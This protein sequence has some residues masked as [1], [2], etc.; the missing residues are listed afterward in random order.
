M[1]LMFLVIIISP[2]QL[3]ADEIPWLDEVTTPPATFPAPAKPLRPL[4]HAPESPPV[5]TP[6]DWSVRRVHLRETWLNFLGPIPAKPDSLDVN[7]L[8]HEQLETISRELIEYNVEAGRR[9][10]A[11]VLQPLHPSSTRLPGVVVFHSTTHDAARSEAGLGSP[12][13]DYNTGVQLA[14]RGFVVI[15]PFNFLWEET[16]YHA[17]VIEAKRRNPDSLG[18][19]TMLNDGLRA[20]DVLLSLPKIDP[21]RIGTIGHSLGAKEA[22]Y[23]MAFDDRIQAG[24]ASEGGLA[25]DSTN[26]DADWYLGPGIK[27]ADFSRDHHEL[28]ALIAPRPFLVMGGETG[29]GCSDGDR[30]WPFIAE[31]HHVSKLYSPTVR[32]GLLNHH[33][34]HA[35]SQASQLKGFEWLDCYVARKETADQKE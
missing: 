6:E 23:L 3:L 17:S 7:V 15:C 2:A 22:L 31:A 8:K 28:L 14:E 1:L 9:V 20:V 27:A 35:Y 29:P 16:N 21:D 33:E 5:Q 12:P 10:R 25:L 32:Q 34:G 26:W 4:L 24:V 30:S 18:M 13:H 19:A 11:F